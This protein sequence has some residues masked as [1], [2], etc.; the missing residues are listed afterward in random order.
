MPTS[1]RLSSHVSFI[2][3]YIFKIRWMLTTDNGDIYHGTYNSSVVMIYDSSSMKWTT[4]AYHNLISGQ[5]SEKYCNSEMSKLFC[6]V[7]PVI[8]SKKMSESNATPVEAKLDST[9]VLIGSSTSLGKGDKIE[10][11]ESTKTLV[12]KEGRSEPNSVS[13]SKSMSKYHTIIQG[14]GSLK[15]SLYFFFGRTQAGGIEPSKKSKFESG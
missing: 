2:S 5:E 11:K 7:S 3:V 12:L 10:S 6:Y 9:T 14:Y 13:K 8:G 4:A 1:K 15:S